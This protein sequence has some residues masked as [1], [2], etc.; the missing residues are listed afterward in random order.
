VI[1]RLIHL[2][3]EDRPLTL[4]G[5]GLQLRDY[6][7]VDDVVEALLMLGN[8]E[9]GDGRVYNVGSGTG[10]SMLDAARLIIDIAG[11]GSIQ[12]VPWPPLAEQIETGDFVADISRIRE[13]VGWTPRVALRDGIERTV[14][15][16]AR[17]ARRVPKVPEVPRVPN[18]P[19]A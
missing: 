3:I 12:H 4:Y 6:V 1:N 10:T 15:H 11:S 18:V 17:K 19:S 16:Y 8:R 13:E 9:N 14:A 7:F 2:A 5:D